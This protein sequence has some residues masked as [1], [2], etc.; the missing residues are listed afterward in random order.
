MIYSK[1][2][3]MLKDAAKQ[4]L[5]AKPDILIKTEYVLPIIS[6]LHTLMNEKVY[7]HKEKAWAHFLEPACSLWIPRPIG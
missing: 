6:F 7:C 2:A 3:E 4:I 1:D 5:S